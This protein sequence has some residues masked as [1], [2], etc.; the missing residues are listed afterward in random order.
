MAQA[1]MPEKTKRNLKENHGSNLASE[2]QN[3][4]ETFD[5]CRIRSIDQKNRGHPKIVINL[6]GK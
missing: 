5:V 2:R 1:R 6:N 4:G 3:R